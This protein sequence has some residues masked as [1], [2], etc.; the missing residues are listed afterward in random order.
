MVQTYTF[1][2]NEIIHIGKHLYFVCVYI[3][4][5]QQLFSSQ[6]KFYSKVIMESK[7]PYLVFPNTQSLC[8][9]M[10]AA[11]SF[12]DFISRKTICLPLSSILLF[13][14]FSYDSHPFL[15]ILTIICWCACSDSTIALWSHQRQVLCL[16]QLSIQFSIW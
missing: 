12:S 1:Y 13:S 3:Y 7:T 14:S 2:D 11:S 16:I 9:S 5:V 10:Q 15:S 6:R 8:L 4:K